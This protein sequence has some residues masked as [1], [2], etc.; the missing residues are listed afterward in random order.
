MDNCTHAV[1]VPSVHYSF[2][3]QRSVLLLFVL[4]FDQYIF[5][6]LPIV[7]ALCTTTHIP[8][9]SS[10]FLPPFLFHTTTTYSLT[11]QHQHHT[12][13]H[14]H[15]SRRARTPRALQAHIA[16]TLKS[17][18]PPRRAFILPYTSNTQLN[19][20]TLILPPSHKSA[21]HTIHTLLALFVSIRSFTHFCFVSVQ[22][23][24]QRSF[25]ISSS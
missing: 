3:S 15:S 22:V 25:S 9:H 19:H 20:L 21:A 24:A 13:L 17:N 18:A 14:Q 8:P 16:T 11:L 4:I 5:Y 7:D 6:R 10:S 12:I 1:F 2:Q 23:Q